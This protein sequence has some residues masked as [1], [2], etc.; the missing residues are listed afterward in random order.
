MSQRQGCA[1]HV[2]LGDGNRHHWP[3]RSAGSP[4]RRG[5]RSRLPRPVP[6]RP[7]AQAIAAMP[8]P[9]A[10]S[11]TRRPATTAG[12]IQHVPRQGL[13]AR[14]GE[15]PERR[16]HRTFPQ[17]VLGRL[18][19]RRDLGREVQGQFRDQR[20]AVGRGM[21]EHEN[22]LFCHRF[23]VPGPRRSTLSA[24]RAN[25]LAAS[26]ARRSLS[27]VDARPTTPASAAESL[28]NHAGMTGRRAT[29]HRCS[30][31]PRRCPSIAAWS[32]EKAMTPGRAAACGHFRLV[33]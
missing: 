10:K 17:P 13:P 1:D 27:V 11:S 26:S 15:S 19:D 21:G 8:P 3:R 16:L 32:E 6:H 22:L 2:A 9:A 31:N 33:V 20:R 30:T 5:R 12:I 24:W 28:G 18:P 23:G 7:A 25:T 29:R 4:R 14:P